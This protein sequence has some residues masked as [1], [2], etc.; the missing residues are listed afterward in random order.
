MR[1]G[2]VLLAQLVLCGRA[3]AA[4]EYAVGGRAVE[5]QVDFGSAF[6]REYN[7]NPS[8]QFEGLV[9]CQKSGTDKERRGRYIVAYSLLHSQDGS[10]SYIN[11]SQ[12]PAFINAK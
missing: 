2:I 6:Y 10:V 8:D 9:W 4:T 5:A 11:R 3:L 7:C 1:T 12:E